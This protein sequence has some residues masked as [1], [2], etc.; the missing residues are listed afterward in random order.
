MQRRTCTGP[1]LLVV[2]GLAA[3]LIFGCS[4]GNGPSLPSPER[5]D[6]IDTEEFIVEA[7]EEVRYDSSTTIRAQTA[8]IDGE[9]ICGD[10]SA[11]GAAGPS[12]TIEAEG[13]LTISGSIRAGDGWPGG[14]DEAGGNGG[15]I[16]LRSAGGALAVGQAAQG[17]A[18]AAQAGAGQLVAGDGAAG[19]DGLTGGA[20]GAGGSITL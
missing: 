12:I 15:S 5:G 2:L 4:G 13:Y 3:T 17:E 8:R 16:F 10:G 6:V 18:L 11:P 14:A 20:G 9:V 7:G 19:G 1:P